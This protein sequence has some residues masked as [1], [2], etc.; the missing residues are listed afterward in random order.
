MLQQEML[1]V[2]LK[3]LVLKVVSYLWCTDSSRFQQRGQVVNVNQKPE[4]F[5]PAGYSIGS[6]GCGV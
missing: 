6:D 3:F 1:V 5:L 4:A 2:M